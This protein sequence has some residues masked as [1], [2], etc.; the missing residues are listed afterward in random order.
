MAHAQWV[1][2]GVLIL[3][4]A[5]TLFHA[6]RLERALG[7]LKRDRA[8]LEEL[9]AGFNESTKQAETGIERLRLAAD[10]AGRQIGRQIEQAQLLRDDLHFLADRSDRLAE[11]LET[12]VRTARMAQDAQP[13][14]GVA[15]Q[16]ALAAPAQAVHTRA[17]ARQGLAQLAPESDPAL[18]SSAAASLGKVSLNRSSGAAPP[19]TP[20]D[21]AA[22]Q[23]DAAAG[24][25]R[26]R[27]QAERD[28]LRALRGGR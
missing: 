7:V 28:L 10:G 8:V 25:A 23:E 1:L 12:A 4:L 15:V 18:S 5:A 3:L 27:S 14:V 13:F 21:H 2:D 22:R 20:A 16:A 6:V 9:V 11:R 26:L 17:A 24:V 19:V